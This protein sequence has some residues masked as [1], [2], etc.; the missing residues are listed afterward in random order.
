MVIIKIKKQNKQEG[1]NADP[2][3]LLGNFLMFKIDAAKEAGYTDA[4][5]ADYL[6]QQNNF[7]C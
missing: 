6:A 3:I 7:R 4:E 1:V 2:L 5:I